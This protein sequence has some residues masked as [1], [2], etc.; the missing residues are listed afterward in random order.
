MVSRSGR[1]GA[2]TQGKTSLRSL[3]RSDRWYIVA[4]S[5]Y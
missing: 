4:E 1:K 2:A 5:L 3:H